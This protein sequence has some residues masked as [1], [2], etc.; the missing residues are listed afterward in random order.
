MEVCSVTKDF[1]NAE[2]PLEIFDKIHRRC[3]DKERKKKWE[4]GDS[5]RVFG[6]IHA[7]FMKKITQ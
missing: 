7:L 5:R 4:K 6:E 1:F 3:G 2:M